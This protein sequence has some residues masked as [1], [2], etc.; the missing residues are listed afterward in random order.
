MRQSSN[1]P[2]SFNL[3]E[4]IKK[5]ETNSVNRITQDITI[6]QVLL[7]KQLMPSLTTI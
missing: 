4:I 5:K 6:K 2:D 7:M 3:D 1:F